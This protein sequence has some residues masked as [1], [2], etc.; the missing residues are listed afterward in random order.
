M[1]EFSPW[2]YQKYG[3]PAAGAALRGNAQPLGIAGQPL[4]M[5]RAGNFKCIPRSG[6]VFLNCIQ[7][8]GKKAEASISR[9]LPAFGRVQKQ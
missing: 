6:D 4:I 5:A 1:L 2:K 3:K 9:L 7:N 8:F